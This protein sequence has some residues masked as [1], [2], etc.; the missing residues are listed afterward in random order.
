VAGNAT[1]TASASAL[2]VMRIIGSSPAELFAL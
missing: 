1:A 2:R